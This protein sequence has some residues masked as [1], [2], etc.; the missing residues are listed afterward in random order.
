MTRIYILT[1]SITFMLSVKD[2]AQAQKALIYD[3]N[4]LGSLVDDDA[5]FPQN[6]LKLEPGLLLRSGY[7]LSNKN[8]LQ[9]DLGYAR[10]KPQLNIYLLSLRYN[11]QNTKRLWSSSLGYIHLSPFKSYLADLY[12][13]HYA[14]DLLTLTAGITYEIKNLNANGYH[15]DF[16]FQI[17]LIDNLMLRTGTAFSGDFNS[18]PGFEPIV[19]IAYSFKKITL[20]FELGN[21]LVFQNQ[22]GVQYNFGAFSNLKSRHRVLNFGN[23]FF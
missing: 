15:M 1:V 11:R 18:K 4:I 16:S 14:N 10:L 21:Y 19:G 8:Q 17:Y 9:L 6:G 3:F 5:V 7:R 20:F 23:R 13:E 22:F 12:Y 2:S